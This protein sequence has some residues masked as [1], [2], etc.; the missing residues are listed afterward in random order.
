MTNQ[1]DLFKQFYS[2]ICQLDAVRGKAI[3]K[4]IFN[5]LCSQ[6]IVLSTYQES[7]AWFGQ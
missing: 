3:G 5:L 4:Q 6:T 7:A 2:R 1:R